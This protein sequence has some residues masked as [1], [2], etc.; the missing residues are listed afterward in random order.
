VAKISSVLPPECTSPRA[1]AAGGKQRVLRHL[2]GGRSTCTTTEMK[3]YFVEMI[4]SRANQTG[5]K[6]KK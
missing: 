2:C 4:D 6:V 5:A 1:N 3:F